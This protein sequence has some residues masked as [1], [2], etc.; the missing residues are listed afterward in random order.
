MD[1]SGEAPSDHVQDGR[2]GLKIIEWPVVVDG[3]P[4]KVV[5][6]TDNQQSTVVC[7]IP[8]S[9]QTYNVD[10]YCVDLSHRYN[11]IVTIGEPK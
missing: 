5:I 6:I 2:N 3:V 10:K 4:V 11:K 8:Y 1:L 9:Y 7:T